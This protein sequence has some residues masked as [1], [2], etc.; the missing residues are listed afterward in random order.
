MSTAPARTLRPPLVVLPPTMR[1][2]PLFS[3]VPVCPAREIDIVPAPI[4]RPSGEIEPGGVAGR[5]GVGGSPADWLV[6]EPGLPAVGARVAVADVA[7]APPAGGVGVAR[8]R[9][10]GAAG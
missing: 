7:R 3:R 1:T 2:W 9:G 10:R 4:Q 5:A 6:G 8:R